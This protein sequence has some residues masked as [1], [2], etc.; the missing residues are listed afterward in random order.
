MVPAAAFR[1]DTDTSWL[2]I[3]SSGWTHEHTA[4]QSLIP[5]EQYIEEHA[6]LF[7]EA[8]RAVG[9]RLARS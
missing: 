9:G 3:S 5:V 8:F 2:Y 1:V 6:Q 4:K 7:V